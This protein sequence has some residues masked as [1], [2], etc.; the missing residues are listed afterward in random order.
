MLKDL[1]VK[2][3]LSLLVGLLCTLLVAVGTLGV[4]GM[5]ATTQGLETVYKDRVVPLQQL[6]VI[7]DA[8]AVNVIDTVNKAN[9]GIIDRRA[10]I[11]NMTSAQAEIEREWQAYTSTTLTDAEAAMV[12]EAGPL[13]EA[14]NADINA[15]VAQIN[16]VEGSLVGQL[17]SYNGP[18]YLTIDPISDHISGLIALQLNV[19]QQEYQAANSLYQT[20]RNI[21]IATVAAGLAVALIMSFIIVRGITKPLSLA[22]RVARQLA[23]GDLTAKIS[24][25][26]KDEFGNLLTAMQ[27]MLERLTQI[28]SQVNGASDALASASEEVSATA[29]NLSQGASEQAANVETT[30]SSVEQMSATIE[31]N[32]DNANTTNKM[33]TDAATQAQD[34]GQSVRRTVEAM[35][36]IAAKISIIDDIAYQTN[37]L[38]LNAAIEAARAGEHG[39]GFAVVAAEVRKLAERSQVASQ[40]IGEVAQSSVALA[41]NAGSSLE[42]MVP[43]IEKTANLVEEIAASSQEQA[44]SVEQIS[45][46]MQQ[47]NGNTQQSASAAEELA[48]TSE[49]MSGQAQQLQQLMAFFKLQPARSASSAQPASLSTAVPAAYIPINSVN[50]ANDNIDEQAYTRY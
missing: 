38:A 32:T 28:V 26:S 17:N 39:R 23:D 1:S 45:S 35:N 44:A 20:N 34:G 13:F 8:Y 7:A 16:S 24:A 12:D 50:D 4:M 15:V 43:A 42:V 18:L 41:E 10:A 6:K 5:K 46:A 14:A 37:L 40:E 19:A 22:V 25:T 48:S 21:S 47:L 3:K 2:L 27:A 11:T 49:E 9:L 33:A 36:S 30:T 31:Q 29:Q